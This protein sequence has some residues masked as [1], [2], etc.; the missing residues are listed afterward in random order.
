Q[1]NL[2][3]CLDAFG[4]LFT[5]SIPIPVA[6]ARAAARHGIHVGNTENPKDVQSHFREQ[7]K[8][9]SHR[10]PNYGRAT[11]MGAERWWGNVIHNTFI[12]FLRQGQQFPKALTKELLQTYSSSE[13]YT[14][15]RDVRPFFDMLRSHNQSQPQPNSPWPWHKTV[16]GIITNSDARVPDILSSF[17]LSIGPR[18]VGTA[19]QRERNASLE[20]DITFVVLSYDVGVEKPD[21]KMFDAAVDILEDMLVGNEEG[22]MMGSFEKLYVGDDLEKD[23]DGAAAAGWD[24]ILL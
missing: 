20:D 19:D 1:K 12:P 5:P 18:R 6:Y 22:L 4:T 13:G 15:Y 23:Y 16:V 21:R 3:L 17:G 14:M 11:G 8:S 9:E 2:F 10:N 7:F 24:R